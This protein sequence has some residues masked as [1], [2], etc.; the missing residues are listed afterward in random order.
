MIVSYNVAGMLRD[1][2]RSLRHDL[3]LLSAE[4]FV[5]DNASAD[6]SAD[7][8]EAEFPW[9]TLIRNEENRGFGAANNQALR[10]ARGR[11]LLMLNPDT[12]VPPRALVEMVAFMDRR[13]DVGAA[14]PRL[15]RADG[16]L[17]LACRRTFPSP[18]VAFYRLSGLARLFPHSPRFARYNLLDTDPRDSMEVDSVV[19]A[20][21]MVRK[22]V[23]DRVG[24]L[25]EAFSMYGEDL[26]WAYRIKEAGHLVWYHGPVVVLHYKGE[27]SRQ[28]SDQA[29][30]WFYDAMHVFYRKHYEATRPRVTTLAVHTAIDGLKRAALLRNRLRPPSRRRVSG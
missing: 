18:E 3:E 10:L 6:G 14:G 20:F 12:W 9:V 22:S 23:A 29:L 28:R 1:C 30:R 11:Y 24:L 8:V 5:V 26:D 2:L 15:I 7:M 19:G 27:S 25:D 16:S 21:M 13:P 17:D 4:V